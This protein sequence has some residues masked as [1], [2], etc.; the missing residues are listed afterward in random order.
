MRPIA[1]MVGGS[2]VSWLAITLASDGR[3]NPEALL[4]MLGPLASA[5]V[6]WVAVERGHAAAPERLMSVLIT[7]F[8][9][10]LLFFGVYVAVMLRVFHVRPLPFVVSFA[11]YFIALYVIE[12]WFLKRLL[13]ETP[14]LH[15]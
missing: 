10:K 6:T 7:G 9:L 14:R 2:L 5:G 4:G 3:A 12:A 13:N 15:R 11:A 1:W 8:A